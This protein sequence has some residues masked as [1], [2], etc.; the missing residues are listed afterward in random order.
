MGKIQKLVNEQSTVLGDPQNARIRFLSAG[1]GSSGF[2][3]AEMIE[4]YGPTAFP[5]GTQLFWDHLT[6]SEEWERRGQHSIKDLVGVTTSEAVYNPENQSLEADVKFFGNAA[7]FVRDAYEYFDLSIEAM[8]YVNDEGVVEALIPSSFNAVS[9]V[10]KGGRD[11]KIIALAESFRE[12][13]G[14]IVSSREHATDDGKETGVEPKDIEAIAKAVAE[15]LTPSLN[16]ITEALKPAED[17]APEVETP[18]AHEVAEALIEAGLT[19]TAR[20]RVFKAVEGGADVK[21]AIEA[22]KALR[23][24]ILNESQ[25]QDEEPGV[26]HGATKVAESLLD[27]TKVEFK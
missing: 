6:E 22:E 17:P 24:E 21:E 2:Y 9:L 14:N 12:K 1:Q 15:A 25:K 10:P 26:V 7:P 18:A 13:H 19:K 20:A 5:V 11:G 8:S 4:Q 3:P 16:A 27:I 23:E